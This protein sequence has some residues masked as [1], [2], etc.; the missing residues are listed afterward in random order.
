M[1]S[2]KI[3]SFEITL[4]D[5]PAYN[6]GSRKH[7]VAAGAAATIKAG[8]L[9]LKSLG[10]ASVVAWDASNSAKPV[11]ATDYVAGLA[12]SD[13]TETA[14]AVGTVDIMPITTD[15]VFLANPTTAASWDTQAE[16]DALVGDR[17]L[18]NTTS[19][20]VQSILHT[21]GATYGLVIQ[22]LDIKKHP[23]KVAFSLRSDVN[24]LH[25]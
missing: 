24:Y 5:P 2:S 13:S 1:R 10:S 21:D 19:A 8:Q 17:V 3:M 6:R 25:A 15:M 16:Y 12:T 7:A 18:L 14:A 4:L 23:G 22:P 11:V 9:V 20:R